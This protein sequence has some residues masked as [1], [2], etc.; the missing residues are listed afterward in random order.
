MPAGSPAGVCVRLVAATRLRWHSGG[1]E[2]LMASPMPIR[3]AVYW[4]LFFEWIIYF[5]LAVYLDHVLPDEN[6]A[7]RS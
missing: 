5:A 2:P 4:V 6:G 3:R 7:Q 1:L